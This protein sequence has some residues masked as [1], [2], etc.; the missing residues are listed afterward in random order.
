MILLYT[1]IYI[2]FP[3]VTGAVLVVIV[4]LLDLQLPMQSVP[5]ATNVSSNPTQAKCT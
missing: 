1:I 4:W 3:W 5:I 2:W